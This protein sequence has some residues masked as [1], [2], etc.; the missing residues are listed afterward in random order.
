MKFANLLVKELR[1]LINPQM[2]IGLVISVVMLMMMGNFMGSVMDEAVSGEQE[3]YICDEDKTDFTREIIDKVSKMENV[4]LHET[5]LN[6]QTYQELI[7]NLGAE[8]V[9]IIPEGFTEKAFD[10]NDATD[11]ELVNHLKS[12]SISSTISGT[13]SE[14][15]VS[16]LKNTACNI[17]L[18]QKYGVNEKDI[19]KVKNP[20][21]VKSITVVG[22]KSAEVDSETLVGMATSQGVIV[23]LV[24]FI[25][26]IFAAQMIVSAIS[27]E[28]IDKTLETLLSAP[29]SRMSVL[30]A[31][32]LAA[33]IMAI[34][35]AVVYMFGFSSYMGKMMTGT[36]ISPD[37]LGSAV[38]QTNTISSAMQELGLQMSAGDYV[39]LGMQMFMTILIALSIS[40][41]LGVLVND[42]KAAQTVITPVMLMAMIPYL[43]SMFSDVSK[44]PILLKIFM[45]IIP[46]THTFNA[47]KNILF[48]NMGEFW[49]GFAYQ[50]VFFAG[51]M[52]LATRLFASD[53]IFT[54]SLDFGGKSRK[55]TK[56]NN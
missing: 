4:T 14:N 15:I 36:G 31:K 22:E 51:C 19:E 45:W 53:K 42:P 29:V 16:S 18:E 48:N 26:V 46:F 7:N 17:L 12:I 41:M 52:L 40:L 28:K 35:N 3:A 54:V 34:I 27:T 13:M 1:E 44:L 30:G 43:V 24:V 5:E 33:A 50:F 55:K 11:I 10:D 56:S 2:I 21:T 37:T 6:G 49:A 32:M 9:I 39:L 25:M 38:E 20:V 47:T 23:P 8:S